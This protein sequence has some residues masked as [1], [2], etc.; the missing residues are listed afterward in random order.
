[1]CPT[2]LA[3][4]PPDDPPSVDISDVV[5]AAKCALVSERDNLDRLI[6]EAIFLL[7]EAFDCADMGNVG[8][9]ISFAK[10]A[11]KLET[12]ALGES[13]YTEAVLE[14]LRSHQ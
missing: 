13:E 5:T 8:D 14:E 11:A 6:N 12:S 4:A 7:G 3:V 9:A 2:E 10:L 1:M